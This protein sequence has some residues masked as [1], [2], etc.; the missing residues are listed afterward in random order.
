[1]ILGICKLTRKRGSYVR[2]HLIPN[3]L[4]RPAKKGLPLFQTG[5]GL[6]P[7]RRWSSWYDDQLVIDEGEAILGSLDN[8]AIPWLRKHRLVWSGWGPMQVLTD[9]HVM[10]PGTRYGLREIDGIDS[11]KLRLFLLSLLWRAAATQRWEFS[12]VVLPPPDLEQL[13]LMLIAGD[14]NPLTFYPCCLVQ[15]STIGPIHNHTPIAD[16]KVIPAIDGQPEQRIPFFRFFFDG[17]IVHM[18]RQSDDGN[19]IGLG[20]LVVGSGSKL[21][22]TTVPYQ[23]S[24]QWENFQ[25]LMNDAW[26]TWPTLMAKL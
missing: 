23:D 2:A 7:V 24:F 3:A 9:R 20:S 11:I 8:W 25:N 5:R 4:T 14:P 18:H 1:M 13:R 10:I 21:V 15:M 17:L 26:M 16:E 12:D 6:R 19:T 22:V